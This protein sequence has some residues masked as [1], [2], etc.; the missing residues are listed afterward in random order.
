MAAEHLFEIPD[1]QH[2]KSIHAK[3]DDRNSP[4]GRQALQV[5]S[6]PTKVF[7]PNLRSGVK[8]RYFLPASR[9]DSQPARALPQR[10]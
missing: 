8:E 4:S 3:S 2:P 5:E 9:V 6:I 1:G 10:A 7:L